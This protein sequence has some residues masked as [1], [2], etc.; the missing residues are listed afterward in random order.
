MLKRNP[1]TLEN[2]NQVEFSSD[3]LGTFDVESLSPITLLFQT[4]YL[5]IHDYDVALNKYKLDY[6]NL[7]VSESFNKYL[8]VALSNS[9]VTDVERATSQLT[10]A[11]KD[12]DINLFCAYL[13]SLL[14]NIPYQIHIHEKSYYHSL[15]QIIGSLL[16][17]ET[18][19]EISTD[20]GRIDMVISTKNFIYI[21]E[22]KFNAD[23]EKALKQI[24]ERKY[25]EKYL[26]KGKDIILVGVS[27]KFIKKKFTLNC[28]SKKLNF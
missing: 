8:L 9:N 26:L 21:F 15:F 12:N 27:F 23:A 19:S 14:A 3:S 2:L 10:T 6:P 4:G 18:D 13:Q 20:K 17:L 28:M 24:E 5:T 16:G 1:S 25:Y 22:F 11:L 7:E